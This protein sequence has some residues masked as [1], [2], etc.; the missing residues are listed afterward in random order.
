MITTLPETLTA[1]QFL[2]LPNEKD[3]ELVD[4]HLVERHMGAES[5][6]LDG[7]VVSLLFAW[8]KAAGGL[9]FT[10]S[11][12]YQCFPN[13][14]NRVIRPDASLV[15][16]GR[17]PGDVAPKGWVQVPPD[18]A[19]EVIS[20][21]DVASEVSQKVLDYL[22][23][24]VPLV[25]VLDPTLREVRVYRLD[26]PREILSGDDEIYDQSVLPG[27]SCRVSDIFGGA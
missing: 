21:T 25:W 10:S 20:P 24:G 6:F 3:Y 22:Q 17:L 14:P 16:A 13:A 2:Y 7:I 1:E 11:G 5:G 23:V 12:G 8:A 26:G 27:F 15:R 18:V 4:G 19:V 9:V